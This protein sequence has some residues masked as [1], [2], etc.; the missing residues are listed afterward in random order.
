MESDW[1]LLL[2]TTVAR[3]LVAP[4]V[5]EPKLTEEGLTPGP[6]RSGRAKSVERRSENPR[7]RHTHSVLR[8][9]GHT[10]DVDCVLSPERGKG[11]AFCAQVR[12][13]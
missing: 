5:T 9:S 7:T 2:T 12:S 11:V 4:T 8:I 3:E 6:A 10:F 13:C 1:P